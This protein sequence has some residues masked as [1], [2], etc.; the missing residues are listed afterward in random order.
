MALVIDTRK[1][2][3]KQRPKLKP[4]PP[5]LNNVP[6]SWDSKPGIRWW[7]KGEVAGDVPRF[8]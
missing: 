3:R 6:W 8:M 7:L 5:L 2:P 1:L 4:W